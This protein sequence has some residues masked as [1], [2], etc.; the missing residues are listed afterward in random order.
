MINVIN[1][2]M[3]ELGCHIYLIGF[4]GNKILSGF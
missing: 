1:I 4:K 3:T 2:P